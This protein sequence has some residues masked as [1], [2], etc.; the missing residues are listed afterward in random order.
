[1]LT[2]KLI[3]ALL[4]ALCIVLVW[5]IKAQYPSYFSQNSLFTQ[6]ATV[7]ILSTGI[8][9][10]WKMSSTQQ[11]CVS[12]NN[13]G[14]AGSCELNVDCNSANKAG[15]CYKNLNNDCVCA[16]KPGWFGPNCE[17]RGIP[18]D[19]YNCMGPNKQL[20]KNRNKND[21]CVCPNDNWTSG[22]DS[23]NRYV[24]CFKCSGTGDNQWGPNPLMGGDVA[25]T[26]KWQ[27]MNL[28]GQN[29]WDGGLSMNQCTD[30]QNKPIYNII[31]PKGEQP[32]FKYAS[33]SDFQLGW[34]DVYKNPN[35][36]SCGS[37]SSSTL[38]GVCT[39][40]AWIPPGTPNIGGCQD[41]SVIN[42]RDRSSYT[43]Q[44]SGNK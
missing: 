7:I 25:C 35:V 39:T 4:V 22:T 30:E 5:V 34:C 9:I 11:R 13:G 24:Q 8:L 27:T 14:A 38:R 16:C 15:T 28:V 18:W 12:F 37:G 21:I 23:E 40:T 31:G 44:S 32:T 42:P 20:P 10:Y 43:C 2:D 33:G 29:C 3:L 6:I 17:T 19:A 1:M 41:P 36:C 26:A